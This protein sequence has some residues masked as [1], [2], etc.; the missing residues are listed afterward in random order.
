MDRE[1]ILSIAE[2][3]LADGVDTGEFERFALEEYLPA[4]AA[5][6]LRVSLLRG[7][8][9][10]RDQRY[11]LI[12]EFDSIEHRNRLFPGSQTPSLEVSRWVETHQALARVWNA[13][14][15]S[16]RMTHYEVLGTS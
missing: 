15:A 2:I 7:I 13:R 16:A 10:E 11:V 12:E 8:R 6:G 9:G 3:E 1:Q 5:L 4:V 14:I